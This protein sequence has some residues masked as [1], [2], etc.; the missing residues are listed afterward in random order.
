MRS[1]FSTSYKVL[2]IKKLHVV[3]PKMAN[4]KPI[5]EKARAQK[6]LE[7]ELARLKAKSTLACLRVF[8]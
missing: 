4:L 5:L 3:I 2:R 1:H 6:G 7:R 8:V